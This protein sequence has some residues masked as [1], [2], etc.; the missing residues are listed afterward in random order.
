LFLLRYIIIAI[1]ILWAGSEI[2]LAVTRRSQ[3]RDIHIDKSSMRIIWITIAAAVN[4]GILLGLQ[5][6]GYFGNGSPIF[7]ISGI[8]LIL[9]GL[10]IRWTAVL[11][12]QHHFT[13]DVSIIKEHRLIK[14]GIYRYVRHPAYAGSLLSFF[15]LGL[16]F[17][18]YFTML[19]I[20]IPIFLAFFYR[21]KVEEKALTDNFGDE[22]ATYCTSTKRLI[23]GIF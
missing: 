1:S 13:V 20:F 16:Y 11:S 4:P 10:L 18:N 14:K 17:A 5:Q 3:S 9:C 19:I 15:G 21:I 8:I 6:T 22:Y 2:I 12:L 23:P 7:P